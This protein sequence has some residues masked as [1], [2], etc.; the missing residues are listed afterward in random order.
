MKENLRLFINEN[1][2]FEDDALHIL[3]LEYCVQRLTVDLPVRK[4]AKSYEYT[5]DISEKE[6]QIGFNVNKI[7]DIVEHKRYLLSKVSH[8]F[9]SKYGQ[10]KNVILKDIEYSKTTL[11]ACPMASESSM[12]ILVDGNHR[13]EY[14][15]N[16]KEK[17][18][19]LL[20]PERT[21]IN[22]ECFMNHTMKLWYILITDLN[23][24]NQLKHQLDFADHHLF[25]HLY[26][27]TNQL[28][29]TFDKLLK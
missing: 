18:D 5:I 17:P 26:Q 3:Y 14:F 12:F 4:T 23:N 1:R 19:I 27:N 20:I 6:T 8:R 13:Y 16:K 28:Y 10:R 9:Y 25:D 29:F 2:F 7:G 11:F 15:K 22:E 21:L 24:I